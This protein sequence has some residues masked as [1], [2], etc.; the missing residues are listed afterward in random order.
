MNNQPLNCP[1]KIRFLLS[2]NLVLSLSF[3]FCIL[4]VLILTDIGFAQTVKWKYVATLGRNDT[5]VYFNGEIKVLPNKNVT[6]WQKMIVFDGTYTISQEE[7]DCTNKRR[8]TRQITY[9]RADQM[10]VETKKKSF[11]WQEIIPTSTADFL[12]NWVCLPPQP[13]KWAEINVQQANLRNFPDPYAS[14]LRTAKRGERFQLVP[15][16]GKDGWFNIIDVTTQEDYWLQDNAFE[17][18]EL[19]EIKRNSVGKEKPQSKPVKQKSKSK[20]VKNQRN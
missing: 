7:Y 17:M 1:P 16:T 12:Y 14:I 19:I 2:G 6:V 9:Y 20:Q 15:E 10:A 13:V 8:I 4:A 5:K 18:V 11:E 3:L